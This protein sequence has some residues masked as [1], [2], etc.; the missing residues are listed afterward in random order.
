M[1]SASDEIVC[2]TSLH[3]PYY[4]YFGCG[5][6]DINTQKVFQTQA[7]ALIS[8]EQTKVIHKP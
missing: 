7:Y 8:T 5:Q 6:G 2:G 3:F 4:G 1:L